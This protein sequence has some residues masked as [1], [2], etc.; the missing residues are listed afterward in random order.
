MYYEASQI[1]DAVSARELGVYTDGTLGTAMS[2]NAAMKA[3][4]LMMVMAFGAW[5]SAYVL[6]QT[7]D[8]LI[9]WFDQYSDDTKKEG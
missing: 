7:A 5:I 4:T 9:G 3:S 2:M 6:G 8:E 1:I